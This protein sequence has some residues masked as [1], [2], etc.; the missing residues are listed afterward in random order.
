MSTGCCRGW[1]GRQS[2]ATRSTFARTAPA[3]AVNRLNFPLRMRMHGLQ[4]AHKPRS[5]P[6]LSEC[7][8]AH[9]RKKGRRKKVTALV[10]LGCIYTMYCKVTTCVSSPWSALRIYQSKGRTGPAAE[11]AGPF[12][13]VSTALPGR[14]LWA[15]D[16]AAHAPP[17]VMLCYSNGE[18]EK[19]SNGFFFPLAVCARALPLSPSLPLIFL[20]RAARWLQW[21]GASFACAKIGRS[22]A[23][24]AGSVRARG[25]SCHCPAA[26]SS[27]V[28]KKQSA[29][30]RQQRGRCRCHYC[31]SGSPCPRFALSRSWCLPE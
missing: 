24:P 14:P 16:G 3:P 1:A 2:Q 8:P 25:G 31:A 6:P 15:R 12:S 30:R 21:C 22:S 5:Q 26:F 17:W 4:P 29:A 11:D 10:R 28:R 9:Q 20:T 19:C 13:L 27:V 18:G 7:V 23:L